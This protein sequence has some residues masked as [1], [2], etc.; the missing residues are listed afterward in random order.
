[1]LDR[2]L[3]VRSP[4]IR[5][6]QATLIHHANC[7]ALSCLCIAP[8]IRSVPFIRCLHIT[9]KCIR[10][11]CIPL[12]RAAPAPADP[13]TVT[14]F[15]IAPEATDVAAATTHLTV[16]GVND[17]GGTTYVEE[18]IYTDM[19]S[20]SRSHSFVGSDSDPSWVRTTEQIGEPFT[21]TRKGVFSARSSP[22]ARSSNETT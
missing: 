14:L 10:P 21:T 16:L 19:V 12:A 3:T 15:R 5:Q 20:W 13:T 4:G 9:L 7:Q 8:A 6:S 2:F 17:E 11:A 22:V 18:L 1:M